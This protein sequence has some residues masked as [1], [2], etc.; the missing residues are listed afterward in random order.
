[1]KSSTYPSPEVI[2][3][4]AELLDRLGRGEAIVFDLDG[5]TPHIDATP[6]A[7]ALIGN[8]LARLNPT[9]DGRFRLVPTWRGARLN[10][11]A[12]EPARKGD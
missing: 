3:D 7:R 9:D 8:K 2:V 5:P 4:A 10:R 12:D 6:A 11:M 1:M